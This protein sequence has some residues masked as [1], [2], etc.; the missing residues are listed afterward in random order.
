MEEKVYNVYHFG[1][2]IDNN[3]TAEEVYLIGY[4]KND[5]YEIVEIKK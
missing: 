2:L 1:V 3:I 5:N 4:A